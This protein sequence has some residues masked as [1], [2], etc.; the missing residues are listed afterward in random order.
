MKNGGVSETTRRRI[1]DIVSRLV[2]GGTRCQFARDRELALRLALADPYRAV[3]AHPLRGVAVESYFFR[4][5][6]ARPAFDA[7]ACSEPPSVFRVFSLAH[8]AFCAMLMRFRAAADIARGPL[9][10]LFLRAT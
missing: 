5:P 2:R 6:L 10:R 7:A 9:L 8:R 4:E 3:S 1:I